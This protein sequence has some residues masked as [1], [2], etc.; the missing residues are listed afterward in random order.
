M[1][2]AD[3]LE[4]FAELSLTPFYA[5]C[6]LKEDKERKGDQFP[7]DLERLALYGS[8]AVVHVVRTIAGG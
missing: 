8:D 7:G 5:G 6:A 2:I 3:W 4:R 1:P